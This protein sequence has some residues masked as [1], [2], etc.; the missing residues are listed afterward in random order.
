MFNSE[1]AERSLLVAVLLL[2]AVAIIA[3][4]L[5]QPVHQHVFADP[6][7]WAHL[8]CALNV[9]SNLPLALWGAAGLALLA[10]LR[11]LASPAERVNMAQRRLAALFFTG[12]LLTAAASGA[13]HWRPD[14]AGLVL[15]RLG[16]VVAFAGLLGL[17]AADR[18]SPRAGVLLA[19]A[20][21]L[22]G[23]LSVWTWSV[24]GNVLPWVV[25]QFGGML[26]VLALA[27]LKPLSGALAVR[28]GVVIMVYAAA[29]LFE[30]ADEAVYAA[31]SHFISG[32]SLK[33]VV[34]SFAAWP[35]VAALA[36]HHKS[37]AESGSARREGQAGQASPAGS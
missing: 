26:L 27:C 34:A 8:P 6:R 1:K 14:D 37:R 20:V 19:A 17:A 9:L 30:M 11:T 35:V 28:W 13:Y 36:M 32:H 2:L 12:L 33:H 23:P 10:W 31:T 7:G 4:P 21:L 16:M 24:T 29:K 5:A 3:P 15:D 22:L 25:L 18:A